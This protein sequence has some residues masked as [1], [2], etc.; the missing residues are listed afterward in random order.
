MSEG[1]R[2]NKS[3]LE[4]SESA[5]LTAWFPFKINASLIWWGLAGALILAG[6]WQ[7]TAPPDS[8]LFSDFFQAYYAVAERLWRDGPV[9]TWPPNETCTEGFVN[10]PI[11]GWLYVPFAWLSKPIAAWV[12]LGLG[13]IAVFAAWVL[14]ASFGDRHARYSAPLLFLFLVNGPM[15]HSFR[16]GN[17]THFILLLLVL[18]LIFW[19]RGR[20]Y[21]AGLV[22]G[23][24]AVVKPPLLLYGLYFMLRQ[25]WRV[26]AGG[27]TVIGLIVAL[28]LIIFGW[29]LH[30][31]WYSH[32]VRPFLDNVVPGFN[33]QSIDAFLFRLVHG[34]RYLHVWSLIEPPRP[35]GSSGASS[36]LRSSV[37]PHGW[38]GAQT[39]SSRC[40]LPPA[41]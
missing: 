4:G 32:C 22:I 28:S 11:L 33:V 38:S 1:H 19:C 39:A 27:A 36:L 13:V 8:I 9:A 21:A 10:I 31:G 24:C 35:T 30:I 26:A 37:E 15:V 29:A 6:L 14:L 2:S 23:F 41:R 20:E 18:A 40:H 34:E 12:Y 16:E 7:I 5:T 17:N 25:R 3:Q